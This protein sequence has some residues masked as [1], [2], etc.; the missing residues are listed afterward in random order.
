[1]IKY[2]VVPKGRVEPFN[3]TTPT[4]QTYVVRARPGLP[5]TQYTFYFIFVSSVQLSKNLKMFYFSGIDAFESLLKLGGKKGRC[6]SI[7]NICHF[8]C[9]SK[10]LTESHIFRELHTKHKKC[11]VS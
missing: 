5:N 3:S 7:A 1:M 10:C 2:V 6:I 8:I 4:G 11:N 9:G